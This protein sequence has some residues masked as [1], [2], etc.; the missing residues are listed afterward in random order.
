[1]NQ[2]TIEKYLLNELGGNVDATNELM[3][4]INGAI[5]AQKAK[6]DEKCFWKKGTEFCGAALDNLIANEG[7]T[8]DLADITLAFFLSKLPDEVVD[9]LDY[10]TLQAIQQNLTEDMDALMKALMSLR[11]K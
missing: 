5:A 9:K 3:K 10:K 11:L 7:T 8:S 4:A 1:M 2:K 6:D